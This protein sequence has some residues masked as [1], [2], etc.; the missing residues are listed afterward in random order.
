MSSRSHSTRRSD[1]ARRDEARSRV[2]NDDSIS[3]DITAGVR[4]Y[5]RQLAGSNWAVDG[6]AGAGIAVGYND[7]NLHADVDTPRRC[8]CCH[9][10]T[11]DW[12]RQHQRIAIED[13]VRSNGSTVCALANVLHN[14]RS[15]SSGG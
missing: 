7:G 6:Y 9:D 1:G 10:C 14:Q 8:M 13:G 3:G 2:G 4:T 12:Q 15:H 5:H 11:C